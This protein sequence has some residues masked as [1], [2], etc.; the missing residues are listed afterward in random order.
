M[1]VWQSTYAVPSAGGGRAV[2]TGRAT[3]YGKYNITCAPLSK[4][5]PPKPLFFGANPVSFG[6]GKRNGVSCSRAYRKHP[7]VEAHT[8]KRKER[9]KPL[10]RVSPSDPLPDLK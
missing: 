9:G 4:R 1:L 6:K 5:L 2:L 8:Y 10:D 3:V 7:Y